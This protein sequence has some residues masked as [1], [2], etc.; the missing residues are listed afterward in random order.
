MQKTT[1]QACQL[2]C[3]P[4][5]M[6]GDALWTQPSQSGWGKRTAKLG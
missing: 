2:S 4:E 1:S 3:D 5:A 6:V